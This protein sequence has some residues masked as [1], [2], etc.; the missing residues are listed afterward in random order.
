M[1]NYR[2]VLRDILKYAA[3]YVWTNNMGYFVKKSQFSCFYYNTPARNSATR[4]WYNFWSYALLNADFL[5]ESQKESLTAK[6]RGQVPFL[7]LSFSFSKFPRPSDLVQFDRVNPA[8]AFHA[9][10]ML[11]A[12]AKK[13]ELET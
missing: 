12:V 4:A 2:S 1:Q 5:T 8:L 3:F 13:L 10:W 11:S 7:L 9:C 6:R